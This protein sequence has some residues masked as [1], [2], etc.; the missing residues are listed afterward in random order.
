MKTFLTGGTGYI[1]SAF[2]KKLIDTDHEVVALYHSQPPDFQAQ[3]LTWVKGSLTN[4]NSLVDAM[5]GCQQVYHMA[6]LARISHPDK[7]A[8]F[9]INVKG[10]ENVLRAAVFN[11][12]E[13]LVYTSTGAVFSYSIN[14]AIRESDPLL[15]PLND[16]YSVTKF[17]AEQK[18]IEAA[19]NGLHTMIVNPPR[20]YGPG[21]STESSPVNKIIQDYLKKSFYFV[22]GNGKY[23]G[24]YVFMED[25][26]N[27][28]LLAMEKGKPGERYI[29]GGENY[30]YLQFY[31][32]LA[33][34]TK[35]KRKRI[36][37]PKW[38]MDTA[39][40]ANGFFATVTGQRPKITSAII[41]KLY[42]NHQLSSKKA[43]HELGY[44]ITPLEKGLEITLASLQKQAS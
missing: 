43:V 32:I 1:G 20:V 12:I 2:I 19:K 35:L 17:M 33:D 5:R 21:K 3:G 38:I 36:G 4:V 14:T 26:L 16:D 6:G 25:V 7:N 23:V 11:E 28:H 13:R 44:T 34:V 30:D 37:V 18:V 24:N 22:P 10:T 15:E 40:K 8:F 39:V 9:D 29:L 41:S 42:S 31:G 27:G